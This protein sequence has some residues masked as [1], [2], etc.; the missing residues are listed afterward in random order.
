LSILFVAGL[1]RYQLHQSARSGE[2]V[3]DFVRHLRAEVFDAAGAP[4]RLFEQISSHPLQPCGDARVGIDQT[5]D[6][7]RQ[8]RQ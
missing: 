5:D 3:F 6:A 1:A 7:H 8:Q 2:R 4:F